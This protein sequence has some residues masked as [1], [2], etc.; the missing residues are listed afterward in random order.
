MNKRTPHDSNGP[1]WAA[2]K[3]TQ[4][5][6]KSKSLTMKNGST[7]KFVETDLGEFKGIDND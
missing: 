6:D 2:R 3:K 5:Q 7:I 4:A 1:E